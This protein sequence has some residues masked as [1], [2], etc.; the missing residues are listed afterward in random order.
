[1]ENTESVAI[2]FEDVSVKKLLR[3]KKERHY[4][5]LGKDRGDSLKR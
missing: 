4:G 5:V 3:P 1:M 2:V